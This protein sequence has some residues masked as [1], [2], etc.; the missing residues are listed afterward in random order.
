[1]ARDITVWLEEPR[2]EFEGT[3]YVAYSDD[4]ELIGC[5]QTESEAV[6]QLEDIIRTC[7]R[8]LE[9]EWKLLATLEAKGLE[10]K[11]STVSTRP[12]R[13]ILVRV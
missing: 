9:K 6:D 7:F 4:L 3:N 13:P 11:V 12:R 8:G 1:M 2:V 5:G 10:Y